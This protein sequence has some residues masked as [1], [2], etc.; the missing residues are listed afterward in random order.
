MHGLPDY[1]NVT[2]ISAEADEVIWNDILRVLMSDFTVPADKD[3]LVVS[4]QELSI[5]NSLTVE[6]RLIIE[7][8]VMI[9]GD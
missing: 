5:I 2:E 7:G 9:Y 1:Y 4:G 3:Y 6:G 8:T